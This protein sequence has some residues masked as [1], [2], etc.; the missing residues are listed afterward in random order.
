MGLPLPCPPQVP[1]ETFRIMLDC[2]GILGRLARSDGK[3]WREGL[4]S[5]R[6]GNLPKTRL[7]K[8]LRLRKSDST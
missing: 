2:R 8:S 7:P 3:G 1:L 5:P 4:R 6:G